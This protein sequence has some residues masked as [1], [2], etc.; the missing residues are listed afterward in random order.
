MF[1][2]AVR[3]PS[4]RSCA[5]CGAEEVVRRLCPVDGHVVNDLVV[6]VASAVEAEV[7]T[8]G[9]SPVVA[10]QHDSWLVVCGS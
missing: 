10:N 1:S 4:V 8:R 3:A 2:T 7:V 6:C 9:N 5:A